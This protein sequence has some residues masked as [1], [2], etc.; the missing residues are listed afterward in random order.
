[1]T[2]VYVVVDES[3]ERIL[4]DHVF[5]KANNISELAGCHAIILDVVSD[6]GKADLD[7]RSAWYEGFGLT[8]F[9]SNPSRKFMPM[10]QART[11]VQATQEQ[12]I[13]LFYRTTVCLECARL[14]HTKRQ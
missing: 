7:R 10:R 12:D 11:V 2:H 13:N 6:G 8:P 14:V 4:G 3:S 5:R 1:M 9:P